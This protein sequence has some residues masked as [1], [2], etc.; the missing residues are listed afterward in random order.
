MADQPEQPT[1]DVAAPFWRRPVVWVSAA[2]GGVLLLAAI[3]A[4]VAV[5]RAPIAENLVKE[6]L[7]ELGLGGSDLSITQ[8]TPWRV[9]VR[10]LTTGPKGT[11]R[12][13][14]L[15]AD[16]SWP[17]W[18]R[19]AVSGLSLD[20]VQLNLAITDG[21][22]DA[23]DLAPLLAMGG[24]GAGDQT[25]APT[26]P[27]IMVSDAFVEI[28]H[29][30]GP[31]VV[32]LTGV[33]VA[34]GAGGAVDLR[35][36]EADI[37]HP[38]GQ[39][40]VLVSGVRR[41]DGEI[42]LN[43]TLDGGQGR[44]GPVELAD[45]EGTL[46]LS[47]DPARPL[48][49][50]GGGEIAV[51]GMALPGGLLAGGTVALRLGGGTAGLT[52]AL[53]D[54][55]LALRLNGRVDADL[56]DL[57]AVPVDV[58]AEVSAENLSRLNLVPGLAGQGMIAVK[59]RGMA[60]D[61]A[62]GDLN[63][64]PPVTAEV[65]V[66][67]LAV[68]QAPGTWAAKG[69]AQITLADGIAT[70][71]LAEEG[72][73]ISGAALGG[74]ITATAP[75]RARLQVDPFLVS[76]VE[77][78]SSRVSVDRL[79]VEGASVTGPL[80]VDVKPRDGG[81]TF[82]AGALKSAAFDLK[83]ASP[84]LRIKAGLH[85][86]VAR[87]AR[88]KGSARVS[89]PPEGLP[90]IRLALSGL[91]L[92]APDADV[93]AEGLSFT[94]SRRGG[95][96]ES[97][98]VDIEGKRL[99]HVAAAPFALSAKGH[100][101]PRKANLE[102]SLRQEDSNLVAGFSVNRDGRTGAGR[103]R[104][105]TVPLDLGGVPGGLNGITPLAA[106]FIRSLTGTVQVSAST[107]W[108]KV[109]KVAPVAVT[110]SLRGAGITPAASVLPPS[111]K[112]AVA[113]VGALTVEASLPADDPV[114]GRGIVTIG[115]GNL[116]LGAAQATGVEGKLD[117][118]RIWPPHSPPGQEF[119]IGH[120]AAA[121]PA[122]DGRMRFQLQGAASAAIERIEVTTIGG[123]IWAEDIAVSDGAL[124]EKVV[125]HAD[126]LG[127]GDLASQFNVMGL[128]ADGRLSGRVPVTFAA[129]GA[130]LIQGGELAAQEKGNLS[131]RPPTRAPVQDEAAQAEK[132]GGRMDL[133]LDVLE[134]LRFDGLT[135]SLDGNARKDI[136][137]RLRIQGRNPKIQDGRPVDLTV[138]LSG[139]IG[140]AIQAEF[141]NFDIQ[142]LTRAR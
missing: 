4:A 110:A 25:A 75:G 43:L 99:R 117:L 48:A 46:R 96:D 138:D 31:T 57:A 82:E 120:I 101:N 83:A 132:Q 9:E 80:A 106:P 14:R 90:G 19:P 115:G 104:M 34:L 66:S 22:L 76:G 5:N 127:L 37:V 108:D 26:I 81:L 29:P 10:N 112:G 23:G 52:A 95:P 54:D 60:A 74:A 30:G 50:A 72:L 114:A 16:L 131:F 67:N 89:L 85:A 124:P 86:L 24:S 61:L 135:V 17:T 15:A 68:P 21:A 47:G 41:A 77:L 13:D 35:H 65:D 6:K 94:A 42:P 102:G 100:W 121:L 118:D 116:R 45:A 92:H 39:A 49:M 105:D 134:D 122:K 140:E 2:A 139:N 18:T 78:A 109:G 38:S 69:R 97:W 58:S 12:I 88:V 84:S 107:E 93:E 113:G 55:A 123:R 130:V 11:A 98:N 7:A 119:R 79:D 64:L 51:S 125:L 111:F 3:I 137:A 63:R 103:A 40:T 133:V 142:G 59:A 141:E 36:G 136:R 27:E 28:V 70:V 73:S 129:D 33:E 44:V 87:T 126:N 91:G 71:A 56:H 62:S 32:S 53:A 8:L 128:S 1:P 20:G